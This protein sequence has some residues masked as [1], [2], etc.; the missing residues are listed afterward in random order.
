LTDGVLPAPKTVPGAGPHVRNESAVWVNGERRPL[1]VPHI[2]ARD[3]GLTLS[4]GLFETMRAQSGTVFRLD[5]HLARLESGLAV[6]EIPVPRLLREW[7]TRALVD[8]TGER[9]ALRLTVTR[10]PAG[11]GLLPSAS[12]SPTVVIAVSSMP[13]F[14]PETY[15]VGLTA[16]IAS[17]RRNE[18]AVTAGLKTLAYT[19]AIAALIQARR[20]GADEAL[21]LDTAGHCSEATASNF[22]I[23]AGDTLLTPPVSCGALPGI[24]RAT[25]LELADRLG[26][27]AVERAITL[28]DVWR[29]DEAFLTSSLRGVTPLVRLEDRPIGTGA[30]GDMTQTLTAAYHELVAAE[31]RA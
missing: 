14:P 12:A 15:E 3:R 16:R 18:H 31:C 21:F 2:S 24:T 29:V 8:R 22:F 9:S 26:I 11:H 4:D 23:L 1:D 6:L 20:A 10:G 27:P 25:I 17:G 19:D 28:D 30:P 13:V 7:V 5:Q